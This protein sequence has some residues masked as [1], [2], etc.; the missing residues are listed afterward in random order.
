MSDV[1]VSYRRGD[2][3]SAGRLADGL[4]EAFDTFHDTDSINPG[5]PFPKRINDAL[6]ECRVFLAVMG[7]HW[8]EPAT[9]QRL[10]D[11]RDWVRQEILAALARPGAVLLIPVLVDGIQMPDSGSLPAPL[12]AFT[13]LNA[14]TL[15]HN[16]WHTGVG[17]LID[18]V[19]AALAGQPLTRA[20]GQP[21]P[22]DLPYLCDRVEP[23]EDLIDLATRAAG[24][25]RWFV[26][27]VHGHKWEAHEGFQI[28]VRQRRLLEDIFDARDTGVEFRQLEW[29]REKAKA[30]LY[31]ECL[32][33]A[34]KGRAM[35]RPTASDGD[36]AQFLR[37][38][39]RPLV[40]VLQI[41]WTDLQECGEK[42]LPGLERAWTDLM[43]TV[44]G[45]P[46]EPIGLWMN[47]TYDEPAQE[48]GR[49]D[50]PPRLTRLK[51]VT[52]GHIL[53]WM[54]RPEVK[55]FTSGHEINL[56]QLARDS[57]FSI[58]PGELPMQR[59]VDAVREL[60]TA[61]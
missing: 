46:V 31:A 6:A 3:G 11:E 4:Q 20:A 2:S 16:D 23:E 27:V 33:R 12:S 21:M 47:V 10:A 37:V 57:R 24:T 13:A 29:N 35:D 1:F 49:G 18:V 32:T 25:N 52:D 9:L 59:F 42:L 45:A 26:C 5:E 14:M 40:L 43:S 56:I 36:L 39:P 50:S 22:R 7:E 61:R 48:L 55:R 44:G 15:H 19:E 8:V 17:K 38:Q 28:R 58:S 51:P 54:N 60:I 53:E 30:G 41:T 34:I